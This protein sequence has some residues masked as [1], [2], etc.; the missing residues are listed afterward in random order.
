MNFVKKFFATIMAMATSLGLM[1]NSASAEK[2]YPSTIMHKLEVFSSD[3]GGTLIF[4]DSPEYVRR[5]GIL[6]TDTVAGD[7]YRRSQK[8]RGDF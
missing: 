7:A 1:S 4:S 8:I 5:N 2:I 6:Y 3:S